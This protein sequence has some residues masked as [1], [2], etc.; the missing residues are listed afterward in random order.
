M[1]SGLNLIA[2]EN[3]G[4]D[5]VSLVLLICSQVFGSVYNYMVLGCFIMVFGQ[6]ICKLCGLC[7]RLEDLTEDILEQEA[8]KQGERICTTTAAN[9]QCLC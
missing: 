7:K 5:N 9:C 1:T 3:L 4:L 2:A 6:S 8:C